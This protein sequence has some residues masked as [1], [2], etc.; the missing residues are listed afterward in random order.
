[1]EGGLFQFGGVDV[2]HNDLGGSRPCLPAVAHLT[3]GDAGTH[4]E[5]QIGVLNRPVAGAVAHVSGSSAVEGMLVLNEVYGVP[6]G[7][8][9]D[10]QLFHH[11]A[12]HPIP[13]GEAD[14]VARMEHRALC[15]SDFFQHLSHGI[16]RHGRGQQA[17]VLGGVIAGQAVRVDGTALIVHRNI[18][19]HRAGA[20]RGGKV[21]RA[22]QMIPDGAGV[23]D[24]HGVFGHMRHCLGDV[25]LLISHSPQGQ[26]VRELLGIPGGGVI[27][28]LA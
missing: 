25:I 5:N 22:L 14:A 19:P 7:H 24:H 13:P 21:P 4:G 23:F 10:M 20:S 28:H 11:G 26:T 16:L 9:G 1:M 3:D 8:N 18:H 17:V 6:V 2:H 27:A 15:P 12:E